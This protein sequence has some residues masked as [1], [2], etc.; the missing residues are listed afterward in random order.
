VW[1]RV[2]QRRLQTLAL[3]A[4]AAL[5]SSGICLAPLYQRAMEQ[6]LNSSLLH[7]ATP[8]KS[9]VQLSSRSHDAQ[10]L[11]GL[12][13][14]SLDRYFE[15]P[16]VSSSVAVSALTVTRG[17]PVVGR[18]YAPVGL[19]EHV[20]VVDGR[21]PTAAGEVMVTP[22]D[23]AENGWQ[24][25]GTVP[26]TQRPDP[27]HDRGGIPAADLLVVGLYEPL[28]D[29]WLGAPLVGRVGL[30]IIDPPS[31]Y[32]VTDDWVTVPESLEG[33]DT[34][35]FRASWTVLWPLRMDAVDVDGLQRLGP[36][37]AKLKDRLTVP[38]DD[39]GELDGVLLD[40]DLPGLATEVDK[41]R[42]E[43]RTT[44]VVLVAQLAVLIGVV[45]WMVLVS[46]TD[47]RRSELALARLRGRGRR[48]TARYLLAE[49]LPVCLTG[50]VL[51]V[52]AAP[53]VMTLVAAVVFPRPVPVEVRLPLVTAAVVSLVVV[54][55]VVVAAARRA[56]REPVDSLL[57]GVPPPRRAGGGE[58]A[59]I[60][61]A[62]TAVVALVTV[63]LAGP[64]ATL[65]PTLL[66]VALGL[67]LARRL[68]SVAAALGRALLGR[69]LSAAG[70]GVLSSVRRPAARRVLVMVVVAS[71]L[72]VFCSDAL[73][74]G[75]HNRERAAEQ[76]TGAPY[77]LSI[78]PASL[79]T[80]VDALRAVDPEGTRL[81][82]VVKMQPT[83]T[84]PSGA[85]VAVRP[86]AWANVASFPLFDRGDV[87]WRAI[88]APSTPP[89][90]VTGNQLRGRARFSGV[91]VDGDP[92]KLDQV[93]VGLEVRTSTGGASIVDVTPVPGRDGRTRVSAFLSC[94]AGC[95]VVGIT[96]TGVY[97][98]SLSFT[99]ELSGLTI[100]GHPVDLGPAT[101]WREASDDEG[102]SL[103][104]THGPGP[105]AGDAPRLGAR[106]GPGPG[107]VERPGRARRPG[108]VPADS[109]ATGRHPA[110]DLRGHSGCQGGRPRWPAA[111]ARLLPGRGRLGVGVG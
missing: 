103:A 95:Q 72:V 56:A 59:L 31:S 28:D 78:R 71:A 99:V 33:P 29:G 64:V 10:E 21:C 70:A 91:Q 75:R 102:A 65:A 60:A 97:V 9:G 25:D 43:A 41:G 61:F 50:V 76:A 98:L 1:K 12:L 47:D 62:L 6:A 14:G 15:A 88:L 19:C 49:L 2:R 63:D 36:A 94:S 111:P 24:L 48:A 39:R 100:D 86:R 30:E 40:T 11:R 96:L 89:L 16:V 85:T 108:A 35:W 38:S 66:A 58:T 107:H 73:V 53:A 101:D 13:P 105:A 110:Q 32:I 109:A 3:I 93:R 69:G 83:G 57:R 104:P 22:E 5:L 18:I 74:T 84:E 92:S 27:T 51:G 46:A 67:L 82:P 68:G 34:P 23:A 81:T 26:A 42:N 45:L 4:L 106:P 79:P 7:A 52:L 44:V 37:V 8:T 90:E 17:R 77:V 55:A 80:V 87:P 20:Q 54:A